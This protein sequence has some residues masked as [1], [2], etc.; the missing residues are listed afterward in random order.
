MIISNF[1]QFSSSLNFL[2]VEEII[3]L[4]F[5]KNDKIFVKSDNI[6]YRIY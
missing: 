6:I 3:Q 4:F 5:Y 2:L 1:I